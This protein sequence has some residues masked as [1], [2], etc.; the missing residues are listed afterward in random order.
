MLTLS[1]LKYDV[2]SPHKRHDLLFSKK[3]HLFIKIIKFISQNKG[4]LS[5]EPIKEK[6]CDVKLN[7]PVR[8]ANT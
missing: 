6:D 3:M 8:Y 5:K 2:Q 7:N 4:L 1:R